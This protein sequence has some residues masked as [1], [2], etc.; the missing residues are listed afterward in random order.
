MHGY[1]LFRGNR[2]GQYFIRS[3]AGI[4]DLFIEPNVDK[5]IRCSKRRWSAQNMRE[6]VSDL[7]SACCTGKY[8]Q[9]F[10]WRRWTKTPNQSKRLATYSIDAND[11]KN[12]L[13]ISLVIRSRG[14]SL[15]M[16]VLSWW[17]PSC[18]QR[19]TA[20]PTIWYTYFHKLDIG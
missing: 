20:M 14:V 15:S 6:A 3:Y 5:R 2:P 10:D 17:Y 16:I 12:L 19:R 4:I 9:K 8:P 1:Q 13:R 7:I 18:I 11:Q